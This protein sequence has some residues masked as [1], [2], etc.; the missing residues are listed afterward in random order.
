LGSGGFAI[1]FV[2]GVQFS[3][4]V[5]AAILGATGPA[6]AAVT[7]RLFFALAFDRRMVPAII[8]SVLGCALATIDFAAAKQG[9][10]FGGGEV[11]ILA[12]ILC[13]SWYS[14]AAQR[15]CPGWSQLRITCNTVAIGGV[16]LAFCYLVAALLGEARMP[17]ALPRNWQDVALHAWYVVGIM[18]IGV[19]FWNAGVKAVGVV[20]A[21]LYINLTPIVAILILVLLG[22]T[23]RPEQLLGGALVIAGIA[24][25]EWRML[26]DRRV[27]A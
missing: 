3:D 18:A 6:V 5:L 13:W 11:M 14:T 16:G 22:A 17:P 25:S 8:C 4:P 21:S 26:K 24:Y 12:G 2:L 9:I 10:D 15:W 7:N 20:V 23:A 1:F 27:P 19:L